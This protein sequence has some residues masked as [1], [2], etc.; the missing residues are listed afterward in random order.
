MN[1]PD[2]IHALVHL[3]TYDME[4]RGY[5]GDEM[6]QQ[7]PWVDIEYFQKYHTLAGEWVRVDDLIAMLR[8]H[9]LIEAPQPSL[10]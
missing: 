8:E 7:R 4:C 3:P 5:N 9:H 10:I 2:L 6:V 1:N